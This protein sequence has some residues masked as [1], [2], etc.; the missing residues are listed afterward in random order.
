MMDPEGYWKRIAVGLGV[1]AAILVMMCIGLVGERA[2][3]ETNLARLSE[4]ND[5]QRKTIQNQ[6]TIISQIN[7]G[8]SQVLTKLDRL[9][10]EQKDLPN[11]IIT[12]PERQEEAINPPHTLCA[13]LNGDGI[14]DWADFEIFSSYWE[15]IGQAPADFDRDNCVS[16]KDFQVFSS[17]WMKMETWCPSK[18]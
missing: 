1:L 5:R 16:W 14:V 4:L 18:G 7:Q 6:G 11:K 17:Q 3:Y 2:R 9:E 13:D 15:K 12:V 10:E 8:L